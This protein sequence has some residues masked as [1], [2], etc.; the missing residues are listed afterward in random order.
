[1]VNGDPVKCPPKSVGGSAFGGNSELWKEGPCEMSPINREH[2][3]G[4]RLGKEGVGEVDGFFEG[5]ERE[6]GEVAIV[7]VV[8]VV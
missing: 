2:F 3:T 4:L 1:M 8:S 5:V 7:D 6:E